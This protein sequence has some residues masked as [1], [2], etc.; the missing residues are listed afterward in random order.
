MDKFIRVFSDDVAMRLRAN[1]FTCIGRDGDTYT[2]LNDGKFLFSDEDNK[3][4]KFTN[5]INM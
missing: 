5:I 2:F 1:G 4:M 3:Y